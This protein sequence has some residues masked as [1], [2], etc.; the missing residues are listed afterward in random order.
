MFVLNIQSVVI[1]ATT[2][3]VQPVLAI[4]V[5]ALGFALLVLQVA[6]K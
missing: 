3:T 4:V 6:L 5:A 1:L 2:A